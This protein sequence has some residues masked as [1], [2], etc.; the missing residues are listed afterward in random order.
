MAQMKMESMEAGVGVL[1]QL[2][3]EEAADMQMP[4]FDQLLYLHLLRIERKRHFAPWFECG[5]TILLAWTGIPDRETLL[6]VRNHLK[7]RGWI[8]FIPGGKGFARYQLTTPEHLKIDDIAIN[9]TTK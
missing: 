1:F 3:F 2:F 8:D 7:Q 4:A 9:L 6:S 5:D